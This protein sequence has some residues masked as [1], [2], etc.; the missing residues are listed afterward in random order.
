MK[1]HRL[2]A[3]VLGVCVG[4]VSL[5]QQPESSPSQKPP[6]TDVVRITTNLVQVDAVITDKN[7][8]PITD[9]KPEE[10]QLSEDNRERK[11]THFTYVAAT[12]H[13]PAQPVISNK[14]P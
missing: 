3:I 8:K 14:T 1:S 12:T 9:L 13:I 10:L 6:E 5:G 11:I 4:S 2:L 7:G